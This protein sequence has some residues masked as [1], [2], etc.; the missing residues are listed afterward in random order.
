[1]SEKTRDSAGRFLSEVELRKF[2][3]YDSAGRRK[4]FSEVDASL[5]KVCATGIGFAQESMLLDKIDIF[6]QQLRVDTA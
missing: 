3:V 2:V 6:E 5:R 1:M 4:S